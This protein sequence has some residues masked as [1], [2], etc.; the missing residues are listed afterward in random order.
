[1]SLESIIQTNIRLALPKLGKNIMLRYQVGKF[2]TL[3]GRHVSVGESGV[4][5]LIGGV[6][7]VIT[8]ADVG[9]T[10]CI[11]TAMETKQE[12]DSTKKSRKISQ[13]NFINHV[14]SLGG[15]AGIVRSVEDATDLVT[16]K[17]KSKINTP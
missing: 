5:D 9:K 12:K 3:D 7:H 13:G 11:L 8:A 4:S 14:R 15:L 6:S 17:W 1:M 16:N 2:L 10:V